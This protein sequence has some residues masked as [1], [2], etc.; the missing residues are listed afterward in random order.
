DIAELIYFRGQLND[1]DRI[2]VEQYLKNKYL[3]T[4]TT[5]LTF[6]W[7][8]NATNIPDATNSSLTIANAQS[9][10]AGSYDVVICG[11]NYT[12]CTTSSAASLGVTGCTSAP[13]G[14]ISW[15]SGD[16]VTADFVGTN[17][18]TF[19]GTSAFVNGEVGQA[20]RFNGSSYVNI[21][22]SASLRP[23]SVTLAGWFEF[24]QTTGTQNLIS[25]SAGTGT[26][27]SYVLYTVGTTLGGA[28]GDPNGV[29]AILTSPFNPTPGTWY[30]LAYTFDAA[31]MQ[32]GLYIN[33]VLSASGTATKTIGYD[34]HPVMISAEYE[35]EA[36][37]YYLQGRADEVTIFGRALSASEIQSVY[38][39]GSLGMC[40]SLAI[41]SQPHG[42]SVAVGA[43]ATFTIGA[44]G[45]SPI[46]YQWLYNGG[47][48]A[49]ATNST[50]TLTNVQLTDAGTYSV[51]LNDL[52]SSLVSSNAVLNVGYAPA[53]M[54]QPVSQT[55]VQSNSVTFSV[56]ASGTGPLTYQWYLNNLP[57]AQATAS[58]LTLTNLQPSNSGSYRVVISSSFGMVTSSNAVLQVDAPPQITSQPPN[59]IYAAVG[60][61]ATMFASAA[62]GSGATLPAVPSGTLRLWL[63]ADAGVVTNGSGH[64]SAWHDQSGN[65]NDA[66]QANSDQQPLLLNPATSSSWGAVRFDGVESSTSGDFM[67]GSGDVGIPN[68]FTA[69]LFYSENSTSD[70]YGWGKA[71][72]IVGVP[73][74]Y[75][76]CRGY[77]S[78]NNEPTFTTWGNDYTAN[79]SLPVSSYRISTMRFNTNQNFAELFDYTATSSNLFTFN[80]SGQSNPGAGYYL[81]GLGSQV[82]NFGG[83]I[84][85]LIIY[86]GALSDS[87]RLQV[88]Q[89]LQQKYYQT[90]VT[91]GLSYQ[92]QFNGADLP[93]ATNGTFVITNVQFANAGTYD[94][95]V[96]NAAGTATSSNAMLVVGV[97]PTISGQPQSQ[98]LPMNSTLVL[99]ATASGTDPLS[100]QWRFNGTPIAAATTSTLTITNVQAA[101]AG[102]YSVVITNVFGTVTSSNAVVKVDA[103][104]QIFGQPQSQAV[105]LGNGASF[106]VAT[107]PSLPSVTSGTL[108]LWLKGD[109]GV[110]TNSTGQ[111]SLWRDQSPNANHAGQSSTFQ[112]PLLVR[113][114]AIGSRPALRFD[115][116]QSPSSGDYLR[117][118]NDV[119]IPDAFTSF[120]VASWTG[121]NSI[122]VPALV[123]VPGT[124]GAARAYGVI[125]GQLY[126][127]T[128]SNDYNSG[129]SVP[130]N[131]Y[132][133]WTERFSTNMTF[134]ELFDA[135]ASTSTNFHWTTSGVVSPGAG[136]YV[137]GVAS[138]TRN[139]GGDVAELIYYRGSLSDSDRAAVEKYLKQKYY[140]STAITG[141]LNYQWQFNGVNIVGATNSTLS[142]ASAQGTNAGTYS[143]VVCNGSAC[144]TSSNATLA[145]NIPPFITQQ[146]VDESVIVGTGANFFA[147]GD[148]TAPLSYQWQHNGGNISG[149]TNTSLSIASVQQSD[150]G[151]YALVVSSPYGSATSSNAVLSVLTS[152][153]VVANVSG[154]GSSTVQVP[155]SLVALGSESAVGFSLNF[156]PSLLTIADVALGANASGATIFYN[157]NQQSTG[158]VGIVVS[159]TSGGAFA[160]GT[161]EVAVVT[162][163]VGI[164]ATNT[165]TPITLGDSPTVRQISDSLANSLPATYVS[166]S[167]TLSQTVFEGDVAPRPDGDQRVTITDWVQVGR[168]V[169]G[170]D[171]VNSPSE[172]QRVDCAP[173][174][175]L[176]N[177]KLTVTDWVQAGRYA[178]GLDALTPVGG[179]TTIS[180]N[181]L[182]KPRTPTTRTVALQAGATSGV[183]NVVS[184]QLNAQGDESAIGFSLSFDSQL[185]HF[186][187][188]AIGNGASGA[189]LNINAVQASNGTV[190]VALELPFGHSFAA[191]TQEVVRLSF[192]PVVYSPGSSNLTFTDSPVIREISD[193]TANSLSANYVNSSLATT[194]LLPTLAI[195]QDGAG[196]VT[197]SWTASAD[198]YGLESVS[199]LA[200]NWQ[201]VAASF[202]TNGANVFVTQ[203]AATNQLY[204][205]LHHP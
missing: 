18:G 35:N 121:V 33:G 116:V 68:A 105:T 152:T 64:V 62:N 192:V 109:A 77:A 144:I 158:R 156:D 143:V 40:K 128:W 127:A 7:R 131:T 92:W 108:R 1:A 54:T 189:S 83:D 126:F 87:D 11:T 46:S 103:Y 177:G 23:T 17:N 43:T 164:V 69:F 199:D 89:Y 166:G 96:S 148:G 187:G 120:A 100:Y 118:T 39:S 112:Q 12:G 55:I 44:F 179:P 203:P 47:S 4:S 154:S 76:S 95:V 170:L 180:G 67:Q 159:F 52:A 24:D 101:A 26:A 167:A 195:H 71:I 196:N 115:G 147:N 32:Q 20:F 50:L 13:S 188:G 86:R 111:V 191:G 202:V 45:S 169:A 113:P 51:A 36:V 75:G 5:G 122:N 41:I 173:R 174:N 114:A 61:T 201:P 56:S 123:G 137:G 2:A 205:R 74:T 142:I 94:M 21:P 186:T 8:L 181:A 31:T 84:A 155:V 73:S 153:I 129:F 171:T 190:G 93:G 29:G 16:G 117:G 145:V 34:S 70:S 133:I 194:G 204:F 132:R 85:E 37:S 78:I 97:S 185:M 66:M 53:I 146:P 178:V 157:T 72:W 60:S 135:T 139:F 107:D 81:G 98:S 198:G 141:P 163:N 162:F 140:Q 25:K 149:A 168:F 10:N 6:Q 102:S 80:T 200:T 88:E 82:R 14:L 28:V 119:G 58:I 90:A 175:S 197:L 138:F 49:G 182:I 79:F 176:G 172:F 165:V 22:D 150:A 184:V 27:E 124:T 42:N 110:T 134:A 130:S 63:K 9:A 65:A 91:S 3:G 48:I 160:A 136:Y 15:W 106:S 125:S 104:P 183:T 193:I 38:N 151:S 59:T 99:S 30:Y 161:Q 19:I 57:I